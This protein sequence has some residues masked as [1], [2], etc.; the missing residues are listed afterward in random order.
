[1][2]FNDLIWDE[3]TK[4]NFDQMIEKVPG[5]MKGFAS[6]KVLGVIATAV[7]EEN[8]DLVGEKELVDGFFKATPFG[9]HGPMKGDFESLGIDYVQY[10]H[11]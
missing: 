2:E 11:S 1:M 8:L 10:G 4:K 6:G 5:P 9:F 7:E 3:D